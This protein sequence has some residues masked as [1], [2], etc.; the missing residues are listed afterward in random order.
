MPT[1]EKTKKTLRGALGPTGIKKLVSQSLN[2]FA[3]TSKLMAVQ[4]L[5]FYMIAVLDIPIM[6]N[7]SD[8]DRGAHTIGF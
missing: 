6:I 2:L 5:E 8:L 7:G 3:N 4:R 1:E